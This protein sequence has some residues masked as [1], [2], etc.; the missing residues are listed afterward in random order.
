MREFSFTE[1]R[2][3]EAKDK[4]DAYLLSQPPMTQEQ[5]LIHWR[6]F[7]ARWHDDLVAIG[8]RRYE[9]TDAKL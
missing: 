1:Q 3:S 8:W 6:G 7:L 5:R 2:I 9:R 4:F